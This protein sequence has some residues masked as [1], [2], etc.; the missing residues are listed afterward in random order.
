LRDARLA[1]GWE[2]GADRSGRAR[3]PLRARGREG[4][5]ADG[6]RARGAEATEDHGRLSG[7]RGRADAERFGGAV[8]DGRAERIDRAAAERDRRSMGRSGRGA[9][10]R[11]RQLLNQSEELGW[12]VTEL[13]LGPVYTA[14]LASNFRSWTAPA[15]TS[16]TRI[17]LPAS[18]HAYLQRE[19]LMT[20]I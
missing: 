16:V 20:S 3:A 7:R 9:G 17:S 10:F 15:V 2:C 13:P 4:G 19:K 14:W 8:R 1:L 6:R 18:G 11:E 12:N 5:R